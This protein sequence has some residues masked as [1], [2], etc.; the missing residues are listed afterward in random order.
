APT[1]DGA[2]AIIICSERWYR[3]HEFIQT[4]R[5]TEVWAQSM[6]TDLPSSFGDTYAGL[7][8][9][10]M[11]KRAAKTCYKETGIDAKDVNVVELHDCF[12]INELLLYEALG[13]SREG[14]GLKMVEDMSW[15]EN[16]EGGKYCEQR[17]AFGSRVVINPSG[18]LE[19]KGHPIAATG[20]AQCVELHRQLTRTAG[21]RQVAG[22]KIGLQHN[23]GF[24][25]AAVVTLYKSVGPQ[26]KL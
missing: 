5:A 3:S 4:G 21:K 24:G 14:G 10:E 23:F 8:G 2:A 16:R 25:G 18:G 20:V 26:H 22:A 9:V 17:T 1:A 13:F 15:R 11:A 12:S 19:S 6:V 7:C